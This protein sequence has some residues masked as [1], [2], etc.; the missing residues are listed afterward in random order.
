MSKLILIVIFVLLFA[1]STHNPFN[2]V[3]ITDTKAVS[4]QK[5]ASHSNEIFITKESLSQSSKYEILE[6]IQVGKV[7]YGS[8]K[9]IAQSM[10]NRAGEIGAD[11][12]IE[13]KTW[14]QPSAWSWAAPHG[15]GKAVKIL[16]KSSVNW[17]PRYGK[18]YTPH[19]NT[20]K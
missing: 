20:I 16:D 13:V 12:V 7:W 18:W 6:F 17:D 3:S 5:Y 2:P 15:S 9:D 11:A 19:I 1:C 10:A 4:P 14:Y 8:T